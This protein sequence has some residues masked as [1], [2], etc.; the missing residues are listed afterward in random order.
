MHIPP[1]YNKSKAIIVR[2][3]L[4]DKQNKR[5]MY[6]LRLSPFTEWR[7]GARV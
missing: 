2:M 7:Q 6:I 4:I 3:D 1:P 5:E